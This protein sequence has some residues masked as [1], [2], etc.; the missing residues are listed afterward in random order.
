M[1]PSDFNHENIR[2]AGKHKFVLIFPLLRVF[3]FSAAPKLRKN[4]TGELS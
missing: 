4:G 1:A 3:I 2:P